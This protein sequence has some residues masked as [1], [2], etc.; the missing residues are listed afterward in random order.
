MSASILGQLQLGYQWVW[1]RRRRIAAVLLYVHPLPQAQVD[2]AHLLDVVMQPWSGRSPT[3]ML[4]LP[5]GALLNDLLL[6]ARPDGPAIVV[7]EVG[8]DEDCALALEHAANRS[9][10]IVWRGNPGNPSAL[11]RPDAAVRG[12]YVLSAKQAL[13]VLQAARTRPAQSQGQAA[14]GTEAILEADQ[15]YEGLGSLALASEVLDHHGARGIAGW[16]VDDIAHSH[17]GRTIEP[18]RAT[19]ER[20]LRAVEA[21]ASMD[22]IEQ[23]MLREPLLA[24]RFLRHANSAGHTRRQAIESLRGGL[25]ILG[26]SNVQH[27]VE[28]QLATA[29]TEP[30]VMPLRDALVVRTHLMEQLLDA[31]DEDDLRREV[32]FSGL[33]SQIDLF[34]GEPLTLAMQRVPAP[35]R[36]ISAVVSQQGPYAPY[37]RLAKA[38]EYPD[39]L[40]VGPLC[41]HYGL[42]LADVNRTLLRVLAHARDYTDDA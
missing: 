6:H 12:I 42:D 14:T 2:G 15:I 35:E 10:P 20:L 36:V 18:Q 32:L 3:L 4:S 29:T 1:D 28:E 13:R 31:G 33:M 34:S 37:L 41:S 26:L 27:W 25:M 16:P 38:L 21:D 40:T 11:P 24:W 30:D 8:V 9:A 22:R 23:L 39:M 17:R 7:S 19:V 5:P